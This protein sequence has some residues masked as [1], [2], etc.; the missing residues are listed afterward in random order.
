MK[1]SFFKALAAAIWSG[2]GKKPIGDE[3][4]YLHRELIRKPK[5]QAVARQHGNQRRMDAWLR[6]VRGGYDHKR[7]LVAAGK[8]HNTLAGIPA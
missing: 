5:L 4:S 1:F 8:G 6:S 7:Q 3:L 2:T